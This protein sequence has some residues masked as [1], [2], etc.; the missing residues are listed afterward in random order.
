M[1]ENVDRLPQGFKRSLHCVS[2]RGPSIGKRVSRPGAFMLALLACRLTP[3]NEQPGIRP[4]GVCEIVRRILGKAI[5][6]VVAD[7]VRSAAGP[8]QLC[9]GQ[10]AGCEAA[11]H[12]MRT[13]FEANNTD[14]SRCLERIQPLEPLQCAI[15]MPGYSKNAYQLLQEEQL[16]VCWW[17]NA[18]V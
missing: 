15:H 13:V 1:E 3:L 7:D 12:A 17:G 6:G 10:D 14:A 16:P 8:L 9:C 5:M 11:V 2:R 4:I 18:Y